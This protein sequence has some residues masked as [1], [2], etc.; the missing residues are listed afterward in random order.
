MLPGDAAL[1]L[2][3]P[4]HPW[5][6]RGALKLA[7]ALDRFGIDPAGRR[8]LDLG[9]STGGFT[10]VL[11]ARGAGS[12]TALDVGHGQLHPRVAGD[13]RVTAKEGFNVRDLT[14][15]TLDGPPDLI[16]AD[17][18]F[19]SLRLALPPALDLA[20]PSALL[21]A[22][23]KPQFEVGRALIGKG[24]IV[25]DAE[26]AAAAASDLL[27]WLAE[28]PGWLRLGLAESPVTGG[29]GNREFLIAAQKP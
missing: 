12:V 1:S 16:V 6:S 25:K 28:T 23:V 27:D 24:G 9:A 7:H 11:L 5:V 8:A 18:S 10:E 15:E 19:I 14:A 13:P 21:V 17:L 3:E 26:A 22:L 20:A 29:D 4:D 2:S